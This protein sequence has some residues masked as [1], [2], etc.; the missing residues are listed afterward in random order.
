[1]LSNI[2][3]QDLT[4]GQTVIIE[5]VV[6]HLEIILFAETSCDLNPIHLESECATNT[7]FGQPIA[8]GMLCGAYISAAIAMHLPCPGSI[9]HSQSVNDRLTVTLTVTKKKKS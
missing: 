5:R 1:M 8:Y 3:Y 9:Y 2:P 6:T 4:L 7:V